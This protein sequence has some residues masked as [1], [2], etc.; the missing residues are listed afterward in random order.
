MK[1]W[2]SSA[3]I[4]LDSTKTFLGRFFIIFAKFC[5]SVGQ[6]DDV[7]Y[8][9]RWEILFL[10]ITLEGEFILKNILCKS[11]IIN[12]NLYKLIQNIWLKFYKISFL[13]KFYKIS[14]KSIVKIYQLY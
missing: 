2:S 10:S 12:N 6:V 1:Q 14:A 8:G 5:V 7:I 9:L 11:I 3:N 13:A 4:C